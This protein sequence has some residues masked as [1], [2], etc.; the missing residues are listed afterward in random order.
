MRRA[1]AAD[2]ADL[3]RLR[4]MM[5]A[6]M[7]VLETVPGWDRRAEEVL[8][9]GLASARVVGVVAE[10]GAGAARR[11][12]AGGVVQFDQRL[13]SPGDASTSRAYISSVCTEPAWRGRG[14]ATDV[15]SELLVA[16]REGGVTVIELH[17]T[18]QGCRVYERIGFDLSGSAPEMRWVGAV[19]AV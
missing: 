8:G 11:V 2:A 5:F 9:F 1:L 10:V 17:A 18:A 14:L 19:A 3:A 15:V 13:P 4:A 16:A 12:V 7:G 6:E